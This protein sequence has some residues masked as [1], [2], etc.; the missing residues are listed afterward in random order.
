MS[1]A[2]YLSKSIDY[3]GDLGA[4]LRDLR[5]FRTLAH[6]LIQNADDAPT[7]TEM[8]FDLSDRGLIVENNGTFT[9][10]GNQEL[11]ECPWKN[12]GTH[13]HRCDFHRF[14]IVA[15]GDKRGEGTTTGA[16]GIGFIAVYQ[17]TDRPELISGGR[18]WTLREEKP[19][20][21]RIEVCSGCKG[22]QGPELPGTRFVLPWAKDPHSPLRQGLRSEAVADDASARMAED[23]KA[24]L[25]IAM[26]FLKNLKAIRLKVNGLLVHSFARSA[27]PTGIEIDDGSGTAPV[28]WHVLSGRFDDAA[29][30]LRQKHDARIEAKRTADVKVAIPAS[31]MDRGVLCACLPTEHSLGLPFHINADFFPSNDRKRIILGD[32]F[33]AEW[34]REAL[35]AAAR[36]IAANVCQLPR[37]LGAS[38][39]WNLIQAIKSVA[40]GIAASNGGAAEA[41]FWKQVAPTLKREAVLYTTKGSW[42]RSGDAVLLQQREEAAVIPILEAAGIGVAHEDLRPYQS[43][44]R[45]E[46]VG[47]RLLDIDTLVGGLAAL[48]LGKATGYNE[49]PAELQTVNSRTELW[50][51]VS[52]L[53]DRPAQPSARQQAKEKLRRIA[54][55]PCEAGLQT[56]A[57]AY[58]GDHETVGLF[59]SLGL[60][61]RFA[62]AERGFESLSSLCEQVNVATAVEVLRRD[63]SA[64]VAEQWRRDRGFLA[65]LFAWLENRRQEIVANRDLASSLCELRIFPG[66]GA[67][68]A[69][70]DLYLP[71]DFTD[72]LG[73]SEIVDLAVLQGRADFVRDLGVPELTFR[74]YAA[75]K[76]PGVFTS[77]EIAREKRHAAVILLANRVGELKDDGDTRRALRDSPVVEC[78]DRNW[79]RAGECYFDSE[80]VAECLGDPPLALVPPEHET[81]IRD[82][83]VWLGV[84]DAPRYSDI[85]ARVQ[86]IAGQKRTSAAV[87]AVHRIIDHLGKRTRDTNWPVDLNSLKVLRWLPAKGHSDRWFAPSEL[88]ATFQEYLFQS[89]GCFLDAPQALQRES[90]AFLGNLGVSSVP[91]IA[92]VVKHLLHSAE[93]GTVVSTEVYRFLSDN[94]NDSALSMLK[95]TRC[96]WLGSAYRKPSEVFWNDHPFGNLRWKLDDRL[97]PF[98]ELFGRLGVRDTPSAADAISVLR[99]LSEGVGAKHS[100]LDDELNAV[101]VGIWQSLER[102][103]ADGTVPEESLA[104]LASIKCVPNG[105]R[106]LTMPDWL[107]FENRAGLAAK[108]GSFLATNVIPRQAGASVALSK[109]GVRQLG[110]VVECELLSQDELSPSDLLPR[111]IA[112]RQTEIG[113]VLSAVGGDLDVI[114]AIGRMSKLSCAEAPSIAVRYRLRAF[115][116]EVCSVPERVPALYHRETDQLLFSRNESLFPWAAIARELAVAA[117]PEEDP[118]RFAAG[119]K[120]VLAPTSAGEAASTLDDLG[121]ARISKEVVVVPQPGQVAGEL[122]EDG[123]VEPAPP[124]PPTPTP[125]VD[126]APA[127]VEDALKGLLGGNAPDPTPPIPDPTANDPVGTGAGSGAGRPGGST[128]NG[129]GAGEAGG[130]RG[131]DGSRKPGATKSDSGGESG[132]GKGPGHGQPKRR[133]PGSVGGRPFISYLGVD[134]TDEEPDP[135]GLDHQKRLDLEAKAISLILQLEPALRP[136]PTNNKGYDL[137]EPGPDG[138]PVRWV[139]VKA[140]SSGLDS[141]PVGISIDQFEC[142]QEHGEAFWLY[143]VEH[144]ASDSPRLVKIQDP[145]GL[146]R[147]FTFDRGWL[148]VAEIVEADTLPSEQSKKEA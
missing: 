46:A 6:E 98:T 99:E 26:L 1:G 37:L 141:R 101:V 75:E 108:F 25:P 120:E 73:M 61:A 92:L 88:Y 32:D 55:V 57:E 20:A 18:H 44:L 93:R 79:R 71:G 146:A 144:A 148:N 15:G 85:V 33:Q 70:D 132:T 69:A 11:P 4:K 107:Y 142:A 94:Q 102:G 36:T 90:S 114:A 31:S 78:S 89:Q 109:A 52:R 91:T 140:M 58:V 8:T 135:D 131:G 59:S 45:S 62:R 24:A 27:T 128:Q 113:R 40:D 130:N 10:C 9:D 119:L 13:G 80:I 35:T 64:L 96:L 127:S 43:L 121:F 14:R 51:E 147:T 16:F 66:G 104:S 124:A 118:G 30:K 110:S 95:G 86:A 17:V 77:Q 56:F 12:D 39:F 87:H 129:D 28:L 3:L 137:F 126:G 136:T 22:C 63:G 7:A 41:E 83:Y 123:P 134:P 111:R 81:A 38:R 47:V 82:L 2:N 5:G 133:T 117:F 76:L 105:E 103:L 139:E 19:E 48:G 74:T 53:M 97:R 138:Q 68:H 60:G 106:V 67:L 34:N 50:L 143:V 84:A 21:E 65:R 115:G 42:V 54:L 100:R 116:K 125:N 29:L 122:G 72:P 49:L 112:E 145:A 23:L